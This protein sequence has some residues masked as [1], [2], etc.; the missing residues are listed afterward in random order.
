M[1]IPSTLL[2]TDATN[3][4]R[5]VDHNLQCVFN[6]AELYDNNKLNNQILCQIQLNGKRFMTTTNFY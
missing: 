3:L 2:A 4:D 1:I 6:I 5:Y